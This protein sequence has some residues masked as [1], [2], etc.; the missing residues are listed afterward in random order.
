MC[1]FAFQFTTLFSVCQ[2]G[3]GGIGERIQSLRKECELTQDQLAIDLNISDR[4]MRNLERGER[5]P[6]I[7]LFVELRERF[8]A[9]LDYIVLGITASERE[10]AMQKQLQETRRALKEM[11]QHI[12]K[13]LELLG[14][15]A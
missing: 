10:Q 15:P 9:S 3:Y 14:E 6:S 12:Q 13:M 11:Q 5:V 1:S 4:Y 7:D 8:G 2:F